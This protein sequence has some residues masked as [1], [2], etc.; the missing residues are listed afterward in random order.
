[1]CLNRVIL[2]PLWI[3][4]WIHPSV[5][6]ADH[7]V[8]LNLLSVVRLNRARWLCCMLCIQALVNDTVWMR[9]KAIYNVFYL[10]A[11]S[12]TSRWLVAK[13]VGRRMRHLETV[14]HLLHASCLAVKYGTQS[15]FSCSIT[16]S[17]LSWWTSW[18]FLSYT[19]TVMC[20]GGERKL[21]Q[22]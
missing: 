15:V 17:I 22:V 7:L 13:F 21:A 8:N 1:M 19:F 10:T 18:P 9:Q 20:L 6:R 14:Q 2:N 4:L 5:V 16:N 11:A 3:P 12:F